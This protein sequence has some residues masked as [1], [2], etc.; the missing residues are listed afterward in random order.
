M[1][2]SLDVPERPAPLVQFPQHL[3]GR[4]VVLREGA[5]RG[6]E[7]SHDRGRPC[8]AALHVADDDGDPAGRQRDD[9]VPVAA[10][11]CLNPLSAVLERLRGHVP[12][13]DLQPVEFRDVM[14]QQARLESERGAPF[15]L[16]EHRIVDRD[17]NPAG[18]RP[19]EFAVEGVVVDVVAMGEV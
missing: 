10:N 19:D 16:E 14:R 12:A 3:G 5:Q 8:A 2:V 13:G 1:R 6:A 4:L 18:D 15:L 7:L 11:L 17:R 9:V